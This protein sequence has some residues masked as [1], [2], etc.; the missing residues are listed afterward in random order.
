MPERSQQATLRALGDEAVRATVDR[1]RDAWERAD[2]DA[3]KVMLAEDAIL[4]MPPR[5]TWYVG[6]E[7]IGEFLRRLPFRAGRRERVVPTRANGQLAFAHYA[8][9]DGGP[10]TAHAVGVVG[11]RGTEIAELTYFRSPDVLARFGLPE[12][13]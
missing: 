10:F 1:Y 3:V 8:S 11:F 6:R 7:A 2:V 12:T 13:L 5:P 9:S 4:A